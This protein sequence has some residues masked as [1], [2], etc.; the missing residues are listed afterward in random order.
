MDPHKALALVKDSISLVAGS[1]NGAAAL[2]GLKVKAVVN[3]AGRERAR[4]VAGNTA[5]A[6]D[7]A[8]LST[9]CAWR[10]IPACACSLASR[11]TRLRVC[12]RSA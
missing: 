6:T 9:Y 5:A 4:V 7:L 2:A 8:A 1:I 3:S 12:I 10:K 11:M